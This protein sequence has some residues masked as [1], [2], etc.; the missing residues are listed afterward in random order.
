MSI[1]TVS[2]HME[3]E[4]EDEDGVVDPHRDEDDEPGPTRSL[5]QT[6]NL[7]Y[8]DGISW[9]D[10]PVISLNLDRGNFRYLTITPCLKSPLK[11]F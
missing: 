11:L 5:I 8:S 4:V 3:D 10:S 1:F 2:H 9:N 6:Q 7:K